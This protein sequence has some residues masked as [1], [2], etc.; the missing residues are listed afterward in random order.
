MTAMPRE[1]LVVED[2]PDLNALIG[3]YASMAGFAY[4]P[5]L[6]GTEALAHA[7]DRAPALVILDLML[8]D[9]SGFDVC[10]TL[11]SNE[12]TRVIPILILTALDNAA[13]RRRGS[14]CGAADYLTKP[15]DPDLLM[16]SISRHANGQA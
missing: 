4:R 13:S 7:R 6:T 8:P 3:A 9:M 11:K 14:E 16:N 12:Q 15:F 1:L 5:A 10:A 2:D